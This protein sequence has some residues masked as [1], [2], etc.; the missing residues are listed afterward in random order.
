LPVIAPRRP[1]SPPTGMGCRC[2]ARDERAE[3][4]ACERRV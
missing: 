3:C 4:A 2:A 1:A